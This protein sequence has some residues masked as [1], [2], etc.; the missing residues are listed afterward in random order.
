M[1]TST[2]P[3]RHIAG[4]T[5]PASGTWHL[6]PGH[7]E[8]AFIGRHFLVTKVRGRF[9]DVRGAVTIAEDPDQSHVEVVVGMASVESGNPTRDDHLRSAELFDVGQHPEATFRSTSVR[10]HGRAGQVIGDLTIRGLTRRVPLTVTFD[11]YAR[12]PWGGDRAIYSAWT[13][14]NREDFGVTWNVALEAGGLLVSKEIRIEIEI[15]TV[16]R[17]EQPPACGCR[18]LVRTL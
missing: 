14:I 12:D 8:L 5:L 11:G 17:R 9:T 10:W 1:T 7:T 18:N 3:T 4:A 13:E 15:E 6:D 16:L 2:V